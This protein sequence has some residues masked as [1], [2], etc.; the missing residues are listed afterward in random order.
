MWIALIVA[1]VGVVI[2]YGT[3]SKQ[4]GLVSTL[5]CHYTVIDLK[6]GGYRV[7]PA[8]ADIKQRETFEEIT[9]RLKPYAA[10]TGTFY[11]ENHRPLGDI[12]INGKIA[13]RGCQ[14][15]AIGFTSNGRIRFLERKGSS[16]IDWRGCDAGVACGPRLIRSGKIDINVQRDGF[17]KGAAKLE[18]RRCAIG[19]TR[20]GKLVLLAVKDYV[21]LKKLAE[22]MQQLGAVDAI[23]LDGGALCGFYLKGKCLAEPI[24]P[25]SNVIAI[26][27]TKP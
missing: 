22:A 12:V 17:R 9:R 11:D 10:I 21:T 20:D 14:R 23:N 4:K 19:A 15:Q 25:V 24:L 6:S 8:L 26:S 13:C 27:R 5:D 3:C 16:R 18:A 7:R 2:G 1:F